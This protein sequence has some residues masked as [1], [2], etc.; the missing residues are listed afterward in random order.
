MR[1]EMEASTSY[2]GLGDG[3]R[4]ESACRV[5]DNLGPSPE[6]GPEEPQKGIIGGGFPLR[7]ESPL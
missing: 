2:Q 5:T 7:S 4:A 1:R 3:I 6:S